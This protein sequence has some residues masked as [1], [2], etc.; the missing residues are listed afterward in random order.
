MIEKSLYSEHYRE[1]KNT[2]GLGITYSRAYKIP[3][4][5]KLTSCQGRWYQK[6]KKIQNNIIIAMQIN[7]SITGNT[8]SLYNFAGKSQH[9]FSSN[10]KIIIVSKTSVVKSVGWRWFYSMK[11]FSLVLALIL[12]LRLASPSPPIY[13]ANVSFI[14]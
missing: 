7:K 5:I 12:I 3:N 14:Q 8:V 1:E 13:M 11:L 4:K 2:I 6:A 9:G 10:G